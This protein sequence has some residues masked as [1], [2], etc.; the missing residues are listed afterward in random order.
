MYQVNFNSATA[1]YQKDLNFYINI[2][3]ITGLDDTIAS[4]LFTNFILAE[5]R[6]VNTNWVRTAIGTGDSTSR[7]NQ[8]YWNINFSLYNS[9][10]GFEEL[11]A[12]RIGRSLS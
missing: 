12:L 1:L 7:N 5:F 10:L 11:A 6:G 8:R 4:P 9:S 2:H 3:S